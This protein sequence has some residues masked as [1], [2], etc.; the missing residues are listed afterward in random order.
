MPRPEAPLFF[1][2]ADVTFASIRARI[3]AT[4][5]LQRVVL[6]LEESPDLH[7]DVYAP[8]SVDGAMQPQV[9]A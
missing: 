4:L 1:D 7:A 6:G 9:A 3:D 8:W 5:G 2:N